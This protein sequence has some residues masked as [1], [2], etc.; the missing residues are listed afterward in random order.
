MNKI[1]ISIVFLFFSMVLSGCRIVFPWNTAF[2][3]Q[4]FNNFFSDTGTQITNGEIIYFTGRTK[5]G[6]LIPYTG[7]LPMG[8]MMGGSLSCTSCH[9]ADGRGGI[10]MMQMQWMD[11]PDIRYDALLS[12]A[13]EHGGDEQEHHGE[14]DLDTFRMAVIEGKHPDGD[15]LDRDMPRWHMTDEDLSSLLEFLKTLP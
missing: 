14:Y 4:P 6:D 15:P 9:G 8:G 12:E 11:A 2:E 5:S 1:R 3:P 7:G 13:E 10:H